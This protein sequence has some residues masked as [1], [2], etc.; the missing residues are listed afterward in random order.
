MNTECNGNCDQGRRCDCE[1]LES[2]QSALKV[3]QDNP[4]WENEAK[5]Y[6][7][8]AEYWRE[9]AEKAEAKLAAIGGRNRSLLSVRVGYAKTGGKMSKADELFRKYQADGWI[10]PTSFK[11]A[12]REYGAMVRREWV[13]L[14]EDE[15]FVCRGRDY[16]ETYKAI[17]TKLKEK[18]CG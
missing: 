9:R 14:T 7:G 2:V 17:E 10:G 3:A 12:L 11:A 5:R 8:N 18:N 1:N 15:A 6:A 13:G 4:Y 16:F